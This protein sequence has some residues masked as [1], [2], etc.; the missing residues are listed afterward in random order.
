MTSFDPALLG[1]LIL[2]A[3]AGAIAALDLA[4]RARAAQRQAG[5]RL[6]SAATVFGSSVWIMH[7]IGMLALRL[8]V[9]VS[10]DAQLTGLSLVAAPGLAWSG[11]ALAARRTARRWTVPLAGSVTAGGVFAMH[12]IGMAGMRLPG[13]ISY[14]PVLV[15]VSGLCALAASMLALRLA[16]RRLHAVERQLGAFIIG[17]G[18]IG[19][20]YIGMAAAEMTIV[21]VSDIQSAGGLPRSVLAGVAAIGALAIFSWIAIGST[22]ERVRSS[23]AA[24]GQEAL[25]R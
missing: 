25:H 19:L 22:S 2:V 7:F 13:S 3:I 15:A 12:Y 4:A 24:A 21:G 23:R 16:F 1:T 5:I 18:V 10:Y 8:P 14:D 9:A 6:L 20:H 11:F 17:L